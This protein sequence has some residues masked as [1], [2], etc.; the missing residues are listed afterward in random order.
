MISKLLLLLTQK[1]IALLNDIICGLVLNK[2]LN[3][4]M[5]ASNPVD[6]YLVLVKP[7]LPGLTLAENTK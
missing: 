7:I 6:K 3:R 5:K 2:E 1:F 4:E